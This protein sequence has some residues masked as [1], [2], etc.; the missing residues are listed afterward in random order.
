MKTYCVFFFCFHLTKINVFGVVLET[1]PK[2][3]KKYPKPA[4]TNYHKPSEN[5]L[6]PYVSNYESPIITSQAKAQNAEPEINM[7]LSL[8]Q[9]QHIQPNAITDQIVTQLETTD[10]IIGEKPPNEQIQPIVVSSKNKKDD[11][12]R[13]CENIKFE[14]ENNKNY[15]QSE[16]KSPKELKLN[17][18][19]NN[20]TINEEVTTDK[21][22][23]VNGSV[24]SDDSILFDNLKQENK[25]AD[26]DVLIKEE[27]NKSAT[28]KEKYSELKEASTIKYIILAAGKISNTER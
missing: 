2:E 27:S 12:Q 11:K 3:W 10:N 19:K 18:M 7:S 28:H 17:E 8:P 4:L 6:N 23:N 22:I 26:V 15:E 16:L 14:D 5:F 24:Y 9:N 21:G 25:E 20:N 1:I 13:I